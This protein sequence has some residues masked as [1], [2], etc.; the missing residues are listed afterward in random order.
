VTHGG[1]FQPARGEQFQHAFA[2]QVDRADFA[3]EVFAD[4]VDDAVE[5]GLRAGSRGHDLVQ[6]GED[7]AGR[8][9]GSQHV[10]A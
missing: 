9:N 2:Q 7:R 3:V 8:G 6:R 1:L 10:K 5:L 4:H